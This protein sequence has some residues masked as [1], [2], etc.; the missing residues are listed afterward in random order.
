MAEYLEF[1]LEPGV[2][3]RLRT[4]PAPA[5]P[6]AAPP[7]L[8]GAAPDG[9]P[10][11]DA[12]DEDDELPEGY[13]GAVPVAAPAR[14]LHQAAELSRDALRLALSPLRPLLQEVHDT[15][16]AVPDRPQEFSVEFGVQL[17]ADLKLGIVGGSAEASLTVS[18]TWKLPD[19]PPPDG[20]PA[21]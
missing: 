16:V 10:R 3:V 14:V 18:A 2:S 7:D 21:P 19:Q 1:E 17:G 4:Y 6:A 8:P 15:L 11:D 20:T 9:L 13:G 12:Y 5:S